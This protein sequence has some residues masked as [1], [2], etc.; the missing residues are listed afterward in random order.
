MLFIV[1]D[2]NH[3]D[4]LSQKLEQ[5]QI[6]KYSDLYP[7]VCKWGTV[8]FQLVAMERIEPVHLVWYTFSKLEDGELV[9]TDTLGQTL[10]VSEALNEILFTTSIGLNLNDPKIS[11]DDC[12]ECLGLVHTSIRLKK[13]FSA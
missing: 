2:Y 4:E 9:L 10:P 3:Q 8:V 12:I 1:I 11:V 7:Y 6:L 5:S 13:F